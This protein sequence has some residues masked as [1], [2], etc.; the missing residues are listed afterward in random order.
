MIRAWRFLTV[1]LAALALTTT[2]AH[3]LELPQKM[4]Y[5]AELYSAV[6]TTLYRYFGSVGAIYCM[7]SLVA[8]FL[9]ALLVRKHGLAYRWSLLGALLLLGWF[10]S[11]IALVFPVN[12][13]IA[14][15]AETSPEA[16]PAL[17]MKMRARWEYGHAIGFVLQFLGFCAL[18]LSVLIDTPSDGRIG[19]GKTA[20]V[21]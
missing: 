3:V 5:D 2:S 9:L 16:L 10:L 12:S 18:V 7:G 15:A 21:V 14:T 1:V 4:Q 20:E 19:R 17:W 11:W 6:N 8:A 13:L